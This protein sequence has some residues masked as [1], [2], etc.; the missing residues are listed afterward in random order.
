M[1]GYRCPDR[2]WLRREVSGCRRQI[3]AISVIHWALSLSALF[4]VSA[5][6]AEESPWLITPTL[7]SDPKLG[8]TL[9]G[10]AGYIFKL[11]PESTRSM[12]AAAVNYSNTDSYIA[13]VFGDLYLGAN[14]H[15]VKLGLVGGQIR[16]EYEDYLGSGLEVKTSDDFKALF[17]RYS[18]E[19]SDNWYVGPQFVSSNYAIGVDGLSEGVLE[20]IGL[21]GFDS[22]GLG[23]A[24]EN[25]TRDNPRNASRG[26][27]LM[28][29]NV[30]YREWLGGD[31][32]FDSLIGDYRHFLPFGDGHVLALQAKGRWTEDAPLGGYSSVE[33]RGYT[34]G[35]Y[36]DEHYTHFDLDARFKL[37]GR[38]GANLFAGVGCLYGGVSDCSDSEARYPAGGAGVSYLLKPEA[39]FVVRAEYAVG[40]ADNSAFYLTLGQPF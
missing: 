36:L 37:R 35:N 28:L 30:A 21:T 5:A 12:V 18:Y 8:S 27:R 39:G 15:K 34:R 7:S 20:Q 23:I 4:T 32:E 31:E 10:I 11:D 19:F 1:A 14:R 3:S 29:N 13:A 16:N 26:R 17:L 38:W 24:I 25:D 40:K 2:E 22:N 6:L 9:G 33:L